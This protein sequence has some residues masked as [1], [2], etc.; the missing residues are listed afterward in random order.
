MSYYFFILRQTVY[1]I[2]VSG[3]LK[4]LQNILPTYF[5]YSNIPKP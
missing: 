2:V 4:T 1:I 5:P 3:F